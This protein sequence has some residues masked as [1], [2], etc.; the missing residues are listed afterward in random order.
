MF[1]IF[2]LINALSFSVNCY[3]VDDECPFPMDDDPSIDITRRVSSATTNEAQDD[4]CVQT[5][6]SAVNEAESA[7]NIASQEVISKL[8]PEHRDYLNMITFDT[9]I[10]KLGFAR[11]NVYCQVYIF[12]YSRIV[13]SEKENLFMELYKSEYIR[14]CLQKKSA[15]NSNTEVRPGLLLIPTSPDVGVRRKSEERMSSSGRL[16]AKSTSF[17][18]IEGVDYELRR[19]AF[20]ACIIE[21]D[22]FREANHN[23]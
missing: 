23:E 22:F 20:D 12:N 19:D 18:Y 11:S 3:A 16:R 14:L 8:D 15:V 17:E 21:K 7:A 13:I 1:K 4:A 6:F 2:L 10:D 9:L 5:S